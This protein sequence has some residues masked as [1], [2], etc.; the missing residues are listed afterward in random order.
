M[1]NYNLEEY[2]I[3]NILKEDIIINMDL[4]ST[5]L[6]I[7]KEYGLLC[8]I[9]SVA[10][11]GALRYLAKIDNILAFIKKKDTTPETFN[12]RVKATMFI[13]DLLQQTLHKVGS[14]RAL[15][16]LY[17]N[18]QH[19]ISGYGFNKMSCVHE[20][21]DSEVS[22]YDKTLKPVQTRFNSL[23]ISAFSTITRNLFDVGKFTIYSLSECKKKD[24]STYEE[25]KYHGAYSAKFYPLVGTTG[26]IF[27]FVCFEFREKLP[28]TGRE[29][30]IME[31]EACVE[32]I[33]SI[34]EFMSK[35]IDNGNP[36]KETESWK[37]SRS[38]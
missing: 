16:V 17:H 8:A 35:D 11:F 26:H 5:F 34:L 9:S 36:N 10:L 20:A 6:E 25:F 24:L 13:Q 19:S 22:H 27:G 33:S 31:E 28:K 4:A 18:G 2:P 15:V 23:P 38:E 3:P 1:I 37:S 12:A 21:I 14:S 30:Q 7:V 29:V 32:K